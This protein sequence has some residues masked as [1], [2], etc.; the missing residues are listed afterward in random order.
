MGFTTGGSSEILENLR[1][2][3]WPAPIPGNTDPH[4][5]VGTHLSFGC[6]LC[7][8][9]GG[10]IRIALVRPYDK[11]KPVEGASHD[12]LGSTGHWGSLSSNQLVVCPTGHEFWLRG[13]MLR[14]RLGNEPA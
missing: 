8:P 12:L 1:P 9:A 11:G 6:P 10:R 3:W 14:Q 7:G 5:R 4:A 2:S 13:G